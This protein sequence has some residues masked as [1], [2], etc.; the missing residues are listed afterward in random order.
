[1]T[2]ENKRWFKRLQRCLKEMPDDIE[3]MVSAASGTSSEV[4]MLDRGKVDEIEEVEDDRFFANFP[5]HALSSF[6]ADNVI[7]NSESI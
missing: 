4:L 7:A 6:T 3:I 2:Q 5:S 1:M